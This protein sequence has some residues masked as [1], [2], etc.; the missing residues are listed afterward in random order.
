MTHPIHFVAADLG[1]SSGRLMI[2]QWDGRTFSLDE[3]H[4]FPNCG[5]LT[6]GS[7]HWNVLGMWSEIQNGLMKYRARFE[8]SPA[9]IGVDAWGVDFA[10][11]DSDGRLIGNPYHYRDLRT[12][13]IPG[14]VFQQMDERTL[15]SET[16]VQT[17]QINTLFQ[18]YGMVQ[19]GDPQLQSAET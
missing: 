17:M 8:D 10:L 4:R 5:V 3:L 1:A 2:G 6:A 11:L 7:L 13:G 15:F 18:L 14:L 19:S 16:G 12:D 9:G